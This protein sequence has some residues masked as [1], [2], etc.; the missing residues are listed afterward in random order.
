MV[1][2]IGRPRRWSLYTAPTAEPVSVDQ[3]RTWLRQSESSTTIK[4]IDDHVIRKL[5]IPAARKKVEDYLGQS[6]V[7]QTWDAWFDLEDLEDVLWLGRGPVQSITSI[8]YLDDDATETLVS[9]ATYYLIDE[10]RAAVSLAAGESWP[11]DPRDYDSMRVR[12]AA[13]YGASS[14]GSA[15]YKATGAVGTGNYALTVGGSFCGNTTTYRIECQTSTTFRYSIDGGVTF[16]KS[17]VTITGDYQWL[18]SGVYVKFPTTTGYASTDYWT[19]IATGHGVP[20]QYCTAILATVA[21]L[22]AARDGQSKP[23][24]NQNT[25]EATADLPPAVKMLLGAPRFRL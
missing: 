2:T 25:V 19:T 11:T 14:F 9:S 5:L 13:G 12:Y 3:V 18:D 6:F 1:A 8:Y 24:I 10:N 7:T 23:G 20:E 22:Y 15:L 17:S 21:H 16:N 4:D